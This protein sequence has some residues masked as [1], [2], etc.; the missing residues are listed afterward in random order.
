MIL[1]VWFM[2]REIQFAAA[3]TQDIDVLPG[4]VA[5]RIPL[6]KVA[7]GGETELT[8]RRLQCACRA[9]VLPLCPYHAARRHVDRLKADGPG[10]NRSSPTVPA[11][12]GPEE[13]W[14][15]SSGGCWRRAS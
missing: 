14:Y 8:E 6:H 9:S 4:A 3:R 7:T 5:L 1:A 12:R 2:L 10:G 13:R 11:G 15:S